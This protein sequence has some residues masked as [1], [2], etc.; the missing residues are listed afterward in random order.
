M[1]NKGDFYFKKRYKQVVY[2]VYQGDFEGESFEGRN[3]VRYL[4]LKD[5]YTL[6]DSNDTVY[7]RSIWD[8]LKGIKSRGK[9][10]YDFR[11][12][13][14]YESY[15]KN[16]NA[17]K[18]LLLYLLEA[19]PTFLADEVHCVSEN[20][21]RFLSKRYKSRK[22][23]VVPCLIENIC[24]QPMIKRDVHRFV[25]VGGISKWQNIDLILDFCVNMN[26]RIKA[27]FT[28][29]TGASKEMKQ[30]V[31]AVGLSNYTIKSGNRE[32]VLNE[33]PN[34]D[35]GFLFRD[36]IV[37]NNVASPVKFLE[38]LSR[39]VLPIV[40]KGTGDYGQIVRHNHLGYIYE[41][42]ME[43]FSSYL[44]ESKEEKIA[45]LFHNQEDLQVFTWS[46]YNYDKYVRMYHGE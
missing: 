4:K 18:F 22:Y 16:H 27:H 38:Y 6:V 29:I 19:V 26:K 39:G 45:Q 3:I 8:F 37:M 10:I 31:E 12:V 11:G 35:Y 30:K 23:E 28:F 21:K 7:T 41:G 46:G 15:L 32:F 43:A 24:L 20:L 25:Y 17:F 2:C 34:H 5:I 14:S 13:S 9:K 1:F 44:L 33:L 42:E 36:D 40:S